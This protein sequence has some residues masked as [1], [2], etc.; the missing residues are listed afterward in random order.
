MN[1]K[2]IIAISLALGVGATSAWADAPAAAA[3]PRMP[4]VC[5]A[6]HTVG[7]DELRGTFENVAFK[8]KSIQLKIDN[9]TEIVRFDEATLKVV[10]GG[11]P[12]PGETLRDVAKGRE[13]RIVFV[14]KDGVKTATLISFKQPVKIAPEKLDRSRASTR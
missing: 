7:P 3:K 1:H 12:Q 10:D 9:S 6:C 4:Q 8:S 13:A 5:G 14:E 2:L 11:A